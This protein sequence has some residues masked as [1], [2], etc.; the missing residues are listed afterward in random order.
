MPVPS[1]TILATWREPG[2]VAIAAAWEAR[3]KG[4]DLRSTLESALIAAELDP[5]LIAIGLGSLPNSDG[6]V[7]LDASIM[8][9]AKLEA[10]A[11]CAMQDII[12]AISV[13]RKVMEETGHVML[14]GNEARL[15]ALNHGFKPQNLLLEPAKKQFE[16]WKADQIG[17]TNR[18]SPDKNFEPEEYVHVASELGTKTHNHQHLGDTVTV[19]GFEQLAGTGKHVV[20]ASSTSGLSWK[21]PG[22]VGDSP[23]IG[24]G[25]YADDEVGCA[26]ATGMGEQ[27]WKAVASFRVVEHMRAGK[28]AQEACDA[29]IHHMLRRQPATKDLPCVVIGIG[30][31]GSIGAALTCG[32]FTLWI[33]RDGAFETRDFHGP[34][35]KE[36]K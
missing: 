13:A 26:G 21:L 33:C 1:T 17:G 7:E 5:H 9:G 23:I 2:E 11:V 30:I 10:G 6:V 31:D 36:Q 4:A 18:P 27:L 25:I 16:K 32:T 24:A 12:P 28:L 22:R 14:A 29:T 3:S 34:N 15:F 8:D 20:A 19:L 35:F